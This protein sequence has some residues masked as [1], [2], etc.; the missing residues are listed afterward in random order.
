M[1]KCIV[2]PDSFKGSMSAIEIC[3]IAQETI[4]KF[5]PDCEVKSIPVADGGEGTVDCF[6]HALDGEKVEITVNNLFMEPINT[7]YAKI[8]DTAIIEMASAAG[9]PLAEGRANPAITTT[10]GVGEQIRHAVENGAKEILLG[11]GGSGTNDAGC[12]C[13]AAMGVIFKDES[14][15]SFIPTGNTLTRIAT[16]DINKAKSLLKGCRLT[17]MCDI[18]NPMHG[19]KGA[20]HI[21]G[22]Q[23][24]ADEKMVLELD[25]QLAYMDKKIQEMLGISMTNFPG[26]GA[27]GAFGAGAVAFLGATLKPGI[28]AV[29]D[30]VNFDELINGAD[31]VFTGEGKLDSQSL[32]GKV[33]IGIAQRAKIKNVPVI[34]IV[35]DVSDDGYEAYN[36]GVTAIFS[37]NRLAIPFSEAKLRSKKDYQATIEDILRLIKVVKS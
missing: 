25:E 20:A 10:Y 7:Y 26:A 17:A 16:I 36:M 29:L 24:G 6:L 31:L 35:G 18:D 11:L 23:K 4:T 8:G 15:K 37:I 9:L 3:A 27:A 13:A 2:A 34:A 28:Q 1:K 32:R 30:T 21:F 12:G 14:G 5:Y 22:P 33:V 19:P